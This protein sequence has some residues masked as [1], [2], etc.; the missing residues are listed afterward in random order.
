M[1]R[2]VGFGDGDGGDETPPS[3]PRS[4]RT[5]H[6][7]AP[8]TP[9]EKPKAPE[10]LETP[11]PRSTRPVPLKRPEAKADRAAPRPQKAAQTI[12]NLPIIKLIG[13]GYL[14]AVM[15]SNVIRFVIVI[16]MLKQVWPMISTLISKP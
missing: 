7:P 11:L 16:W 5:Y 9:V 4:N 14:L 12:P 3:R 2:R 13:A 8:R 10:T 6:K 1:V 15:D